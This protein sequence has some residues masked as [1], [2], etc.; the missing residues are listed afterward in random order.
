[1]KTLKSLILIAILCAAW[2]G[3]AV[4][5]KPRKPKTTLTVSLDYWVR[6]KTVDANGLAEFWATPPFKITLD[7]LPGQWF[8]WSETAE[9]YY[10]AIETG[11]P[12]KH[13]GRVWRVKG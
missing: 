4:T 8:W 10:G 3:E 5:L 6:F 9:N 13:P 12:N 1:M 2:P 7:E 11:V